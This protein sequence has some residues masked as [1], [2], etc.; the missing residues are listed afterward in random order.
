[1]RVYHEQLSVHTLSTFLG[2]CVDFF[3]VLSREFAMAG[4]CGTEAEDH[5]VHE[6]ATKVLYKYT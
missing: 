3:T 2:F 4:A 1:M 5:T 6:A